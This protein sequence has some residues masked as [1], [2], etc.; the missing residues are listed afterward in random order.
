MAKTN[1]K[2]APEKEAKTSA[3]VEEAPAEKEN[4]PSETEL[5]QQELD[6]TKEMLLRTAAEFDNYKKRTE[7]EKNDLSA[8]VKASCLK[9]LL[10]VA[11]NIARAAQCESGSE[12]YVKGLDM[13]VKQL[14][15]TLDQLG[16]KEMDCL[17]QPFDP[18][19]HEA[20]MHVE[21]EQYEANTVI[22]VLQAGY[23]CGDMVIRPAMVKVA[24]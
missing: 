12:D 18:N 10:P 13:I 5:L 4:E 20:V 23:Q 2:T 1:K 9:A 14:C 8:F 6:K 16:L 19:R 11:D 3:A 7:K 15:N 22:E 17:N 24:N 21:D